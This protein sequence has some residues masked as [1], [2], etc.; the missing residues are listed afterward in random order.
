MYNQIVVL[1]GDRPTAPEEL[2]WCGGLW[3]SS[4]YLSHVFRV[5]RRKREG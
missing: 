2:T 3:E 5:L 1:R 4:F